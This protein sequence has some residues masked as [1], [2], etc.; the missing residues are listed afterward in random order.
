MVSAR[1]L[2]EAIVSH[3][4]D[5]CRRDDT[6]IELGETL[7]CISDWP[8]ATALFSSRFDACALN[9]LSDGAMDR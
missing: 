5:D 8:T 3:D 6:L 1:P 7:S 2:F 9:V 4:V